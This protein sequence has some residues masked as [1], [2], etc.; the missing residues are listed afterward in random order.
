M[1]KW[2]MGERNRE[3]KEQM[4]IDEV[5]CRMRKKNDDAGKRERKG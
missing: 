1:V 3:R 5:N 2:K 4:K